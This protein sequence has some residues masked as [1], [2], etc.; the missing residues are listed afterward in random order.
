MLTACSQG[1]TKGGESGTGSTSSASSYSTL[2][3]DMSGSDH[4]MI[5]DDVYTDGSSQTRIS[6]LIDFN[7]SADFVVTV[8]ADMGNGF[9]MTY[10]IRGDGTSVVTRSAAYTLDNDAHGWADNSTTFDRG[11]AMSG[12]DGDAQIGRWM[13]GFS[14]EEHGPAMVDFLEQAAG[15]AWQAHLALLAEAG[16]TAPASAEA[17]LGGLGASKVNLT[18]LPPIGGNRPIPLPNPGGAKPPGYIPPNINP[19]RP[20]PGRPPTPPAPPARPPRPV[21]PPARPTPQP[22]PPATPA[23]RWPGWPGRPAPIFPEPRP[24]L[25][26]PWAQQLLTRWGPPIGY[27][28]YQWLRNLYNGTDGGTG[29]ADGGTRPPAPPTIPPAIP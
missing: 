25:I 10:A 22:A 7:T 2:V 24:P 11:A 8:T 21:A 13:L 23:P 1:A 6:T 5:W 14:Y 29:Q 18:R 28:I 17:A 9:D 3:K 12:E 4:T 16:Y 20:P 27:A 15:Q 26:P 19:P